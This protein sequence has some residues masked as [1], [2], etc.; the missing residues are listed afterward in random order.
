MDHLVSIGC[1]RSKLDPCLVF[2]PTQGDVLK[3]AGD[4][5]PWDGYAAI[6]VDDMMGRATRP[7]IKWLQ[8]RLEEDGFIVKLQVVE[9]GESFE[10]VGERCEELEDGFLLD[11]FQYCDQRLAEVPLMDD[12]WKQ[13]YAECTAEELSSF[14]TALGSGSWVTGRTR[15]ELQYE[16]SFAA[17]AVNGLKI[18]DVLRLNKTVRVLRD[19]RWR[20][21]MRVPKIDI[22]NGMR[23][24]CIADCGEG[25]QRPDTWEKCQGGRCVGLMSMAPVGTEGAFALVW[26]NSGKLSRVTHSSF[27]GE[28][29]NVVETVDMALAIELLVEEV[30]YGVMPSRRARM[31]A[32][33]DGAASSEAVERAPIGIEVHTDSKSLVDRVASR[34]L[35]A[36]MAKRRKQDVADLQ[37]LTFEEQLRDPLFH[38][39]GK[40]IPMDPLTKPASQAKQTSARLREVL[41]GGYY[42][43]ESA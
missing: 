23:V 40:A 25:E 4:T 37:E 12:R 38:C 16:T 3:V 13:R 39:S 15:P 11:Q 22:A 31:E 29:V 35:E 8:Q 33:R 1:V 10:Y 2:V 30:E 6:H 43:P 7:V 17:S 42:R 14:R 28:C 26:I 18:R 21:R 27:D 5:S 32:M 34:M 19:P 20:Y 41:E 36:G 24:V 9:V